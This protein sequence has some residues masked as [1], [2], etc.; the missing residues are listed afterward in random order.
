[1]GVFFDA[2]ATDCDGVLPAFTNST[3][4]VCLILGGQAAGGITGAEFRIDGFPA[5]GWFATWQPPPG[6]DLPCA[7]GAPHL[8]G[9]HV[10]WPTCQQGTNGVVLVGRY[11][12]VVVA[13]AGPLQLFVRGHS[14]PA[15][16]EFACPNVFLCDAQ[17]TQVCVAGGET[18]IGGTLPCPTVRVS[19]SSWSGVKELYRGD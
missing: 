5:S 13:D 14:I 18:M 16:P 2:A 11:S 10:A 9:A 1:L 17:F 19:P 3:L 4:Y 6:C 12:I 15:N 8:G 7:L